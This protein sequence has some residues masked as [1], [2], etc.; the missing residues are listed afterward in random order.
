MP[1]SIAP[2]LNDECDEGDQQC[3][4]EGYEPYADEGMC[5]CPAEVELED[6]LGAPESVIFYLICLHWPPW[7]RS[8][9]RQ[10]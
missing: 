6:S 2:A 4:L 7:V 8:H 3:E 5:A 1:E 10:F 9:P